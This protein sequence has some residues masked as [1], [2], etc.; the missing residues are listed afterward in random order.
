MLCM[1]SVEGLYLAPYSLEKVNFFGVD[2]KIRTMGKLL[3]T[4]LEHLYATHQR[5]FNIVLKD[6][7]AYTTN[8]VGDQRIIIREESEKHLLSQP[9]RIGDSNYYL[10]TRISRQQALNNIR[11]I[12]IGVRLYDGIKVYYRDR[13][14]DLN[15]L[16]SWE[17]GQRRG[18]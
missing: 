1:N 8:S 5:G 10:D 16:Y 6:E 9:S 7:L 13:H 15:Q 2:M 3:K 18:R 4:L 14:I 17:A 11:R 12:V